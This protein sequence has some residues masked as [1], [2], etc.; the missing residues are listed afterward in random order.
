MPGG[1]HLDQPHRDLLGDHAVLERDGLHRAGLPEVLGDH[2]AVVEGPLDLQRPA[3]AGVPVV[4][5]GGVGR[6]LGVAVDQPH[7]G[8]LDR[9]VEAEGDRLAGAV[10]GHPPAGLGD[11]VEQVGRHEG[12]R[13][14]GHV[15]GGR[16][17]PRRPDGGRVGEVAGLDLRDGRERGPAL[18]GTG[19][20]A[21]LLGAHRVGRLLGG[22]AGSSSPRSSS[23]RPSVASSSITVR[24]ATHGTQPAAAPRRRLSSTWRWR[25]A[26]SGSGPVSAAA[27]AASSA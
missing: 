20:A 22:V 18:G 13:A 4:A 2:R 26:V 10:A 15:L 24:P 8:H 27:G 16:R 21:G 23:H 25:L 14:A 19:V 5:A 9:L 6:G 17:R 7:L 1:G 12:H 3:V 11:A